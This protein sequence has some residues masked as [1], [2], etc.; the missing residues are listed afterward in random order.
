[1]KNKFIKISGRGKADLIIK[2]ENRE[3]IID[4]KT[5]GM[6]ELQLDFYSILYA[7][8]A[9]LTEKYI[10]NVD[11]CSLEKP[12]K[13]R[14]VKD[15]IGREKIDFEGKNKTLKVLETELDEF[16]KLG[17]YERTDRASSCGR[18]EYMEICKVGEIV[19]D[20]K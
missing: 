19:G 9:D 18:C 15:E 12:S 14:L 10:F 4:F 3:F 2:T 20:E 1:L 17:V 8:E 13:I 6:N 7:G 16:L 5:G 11:K